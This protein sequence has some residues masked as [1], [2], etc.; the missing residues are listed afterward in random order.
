[1]TNTYGT[2]ISGI[3]VI[4]VQSTT[5][6]ITVQPLDQTTQAGGTV[7]F[8]VQANGA[9]P[10]TY[11]W[12]KNGNLLSR[13]TV[14][15]N[16]SIYSFAAAASDNNAQISVTVSNTYGVLTTRTATLT[17]TSTCTIPSVPSAIYPIANEANSPT[18][19]VFSWSPQGSDACPVKYDFLVETSSTC[20]PNQAVFTASNLQLP[21]TSITGLAFNT[22]YYWCV[23]ATNT[24][25]P[26][27]VRDF[28]PL[29]TFSTHGATVAQPFNITTNPITT[30]ASAASGHS[31]VVVSADGGEPGAVGIFYV[32]APLTNT[33]TRLG[34]N[35]I[36][37]SGHYSIVTDINFITNN[38]PQN[39]TYTFEFSTQVRRNG[40][41]TLQQSP[42]SAHAFYFYNAAS[43]LPAP[44][45]VR[46]VPGHESH[47]GEFQWD[48]VSGTTSY[49]IW[50]RVGTDECDPSHLILGQPTV[51]YLG[52]RPFMLVATVPSTTTTYNDITNQNFPLP[53][54]LDH[55]VAYFVTDEDAAGSS[56]PRSSS[57]VFHNPVAPIRGSNQNIQFF[58]NPGSSVQQGYLCGISDAGYFDGSVAPDLKVDIR[59]KPAI[60][61]QGCLPRDGFSF[62]SPQSEILGNLDSLV[63][64]SYSSADQRCIPITTQTPL[65]FSV[66]NY[67]VQTCL[68]DP[69]ENHER[70]CEVNGVNA[71]TDPAFPNFHGLDAVLPDGTSTNV[72]ARWTQPGVTD[73]TL[74][75]KKLVLQWT[76]HV[77]SNGSPIFD[78]PTA[79]RDITDI[80]ATSYQITGLDTD[81]DY[82]VQITLI[83][84][85]NQPHTPGM[86]LRVHTTNIKPIITDLQVLPSES[87]NEP[88]KLVIQFKVKSVFVGRDDFHVSMDSMKYRFDGAGDGVTIQ[89]KY[90]SSVTS[91]NNL[92]LASSVS[93]SNTSPV[94][95]V[96]FDS[97]AYFNGQKGMQIGLQVNDSY[98]TK[99]DFTWSGQ[100]T[101]LRGTSEVEANSNS[102]AMDCSLSSRSTTR[103]QGPLS[104]MLG[105]FISSILL[106]RITS[107]RKRRKSI[108]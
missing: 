4:H 64:E 105:L 85:R 3:V 34:Q 87:P 103:N 21:N 93:N 33:K 91:L 38:L 30:N 107:K 22:T 88:Y 11:T 9:L 59:I 73:A 61:G 20:D 89:S 49:K 86:P 48:A 16:S 39:Q 101:V 35:L 28:Q 80:Q 94:I 68:I 13:S 77:D 71:Y 8:T 19:F 99:S 82:W 37:P 5:P 72:I 43:G 97:L 2:T 102:S 27:L 92:L 26:S 95:K 76:S 42:E 62:D 84:A 41:S 1:M 12:Y 79:T 7:S 65:T 52:N 58:S 31:V 83:D 100:N 18:A 32:Y 69:S 98:G 60:A 74:T 96:T 54:S 81:A 108:L 44:Q 50:R 55:G 106:I 36:G 24:Q 10:I 56:S 47:I 46:L 40:T 75:V 57:I 6:S 90:L 70:V 29:G 25:T 63:S 53:S 51:C 15:S 104:L 67:C 78:D 66:S 17:V 23:R 14:T 45:N